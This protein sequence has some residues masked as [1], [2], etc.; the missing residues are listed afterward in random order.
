MPL[1]ALC[2]SILSAANPKRSAIRA[3]VAKTDQ[4][5]PQAHH[6]NPLSFVFLPPQTPKNYLL[7]MN[8]YTKFESSLNLQLKQQNIHE[9]KNTLQAEQAIKTVSNI[10]IDLRKLVLQNGFIDQQQEIAFFKQT[11]PKLLGNLIYFTHIHDFELKRQI[12]GNKDFKRYI[13]LKLDIFQKLFQENIDF[14]S[15]MQNNSSHFDATYFMR[16]NNPTPASNTNYDYYL[17]PEFNTSHD[18]LLAMMTA[19][20]RLVQHLLKAK[21]N[22]PE[23]TNDDILLYWTDSKAAFVEIVYALQVSGSINSGKADIKE[24][25]NTL[26]KAFNYEVVDLYRAFNEFNNR[27]ID[28]TKY[29]TH[30]TDRLTLKLDKIDIFNPSL[31]S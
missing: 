5:E 21:Q 2:G 3:S 15:Y 28:R 7:S 14:I 30:L 1:C 6:P 19:H 31:Q 10:L 17:D 12:M 18:H 29:L 20:K 24:V 16:Y 11:K 25:C 27:K 26:E 23:N 9:P 4:R 22:E 8:T 13:R